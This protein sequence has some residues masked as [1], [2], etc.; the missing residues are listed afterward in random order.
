M[1]LLLAVL[2]LGFLLSACNDGDAPPNFTDGSVNLDGSGA[3][4]LGGKD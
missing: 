3:V 1:R 2:C 4:D